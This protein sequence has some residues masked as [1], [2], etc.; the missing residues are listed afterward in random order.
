MNPKV[1]HVTPTE[2]HTLIV[3]FESGE[4][5]EFDVKP[6]LD[7]GIFTE[8][9]DKGK[10]QSVKVVAGSVEWLHGQDLSYDTLYVA[11]VPVMDEDSH[12]AVVNQ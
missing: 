4:R 8:L 12:Y 11:G 7:S 6:Y 5:R 2:N 9:Q 3:M 10:F 1:K